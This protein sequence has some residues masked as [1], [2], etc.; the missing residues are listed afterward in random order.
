MDKMLNN[1]KKIGKNVNG[2]TLTRRQKVEEKK[3]RIYTIEFQMVYKM[4]KC[5]Q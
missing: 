4:T 3:H 5:I 1:N 2:K